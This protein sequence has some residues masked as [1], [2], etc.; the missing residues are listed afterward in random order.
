MRDS[1]HPDDPQNDRENV[2]SNVEKKVKLFWKV[3][4]AAFHERTYRLSTMV[5]VV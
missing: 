5:V 4:R 1:W 3:S 2:L